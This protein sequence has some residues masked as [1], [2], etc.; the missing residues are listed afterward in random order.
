MQIS[1]KITLRAWETKVFSINPC[2]MYSPA[3]W[4]LPPSTWLQPPLPCCPLKPVKKIVFDFW[5]D[6]PCCH[7]S[8]SLVIR[9]V[10]SSLFNG[11]SSS[12]I[13][14]PPS[15]CHLHVPGAQ[16]MIA[17]QWRWISWAHQRHPF[18]AHHRYMHRRQMHHRYLCVVHW[19]SA[20]G[21][22]PGVNK[23]WRS[24]S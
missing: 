11:P 12:S 7:P 4:P 14:F 5:F 22:K 2:A 10:G 17:V 21:T 8:L 18:F 13:P 1:V 20:K 9:D 19:L 15:Q 24:K 6:Q 16:T 23:V 3:S